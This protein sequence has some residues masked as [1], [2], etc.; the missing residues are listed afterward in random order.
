MRLIVFNHLGFLFPR[1][2]FPH[3]HILMGDMTSAKMLLTNHPCT[4]SEVQFS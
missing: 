2:F 1:I 4:Y 3:F